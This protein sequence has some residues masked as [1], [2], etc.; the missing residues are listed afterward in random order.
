[1]TD[2]QYSLD[3]KL[4]QMLW[5]VCFKNYISHLQAAAKDKVEKS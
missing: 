5:N 4:E 3:R 1:V 2:L